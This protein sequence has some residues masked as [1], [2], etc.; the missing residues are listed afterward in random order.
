MAAG[1][2]FI[3]WA[4]PVPVNPANF[5]NYK[6]DDVLVSA[7]GPFSNIVLAFVCS[8]AV[9][10]LVLGINSFH[11]DTAPIFTDGMEFLVKMFYGGIYLNIVLA[12]FNMIPV[13]PLDGSHILAT[14][15]PDAAARRFRSVGFLGIFIIIFLMRVPFVSAAFTSVIHGIFTPF[16][17]MISLF[18]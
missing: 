17:S 1:S 4:K 6:R 16:Q 5:S 7:V 8:L 11:N 2:V 13:P 12:V 3:A 9:V 14:L 15:L 18:V 10:A